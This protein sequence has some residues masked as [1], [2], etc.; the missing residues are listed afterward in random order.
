VKQAR[1]AEPW[2]SLLTGPDRDFIAAVRGELIPDPGLLTMRSLHAL[3]D[4]DRERYAM[5]RTKWHRHLPIIRL[6]SRDQ[7]YEQFE[8]D[9][10]EDEWS[11]GDYAEGHP[12][13]VLDGPPGVGKSTLL[14][15]EMASSLALAARSRWLDE[16]DEVAPPSTSYR[17]LPTYQPVIR[18]RHTSASTVPTIVA[19]LLGKLGR[20]VG[21]RPHESLA[22]ALKECRTSLI[23]FDEVQRVNFDRK[24]GQHV[25][26]LLRELSE[27]HSRLILAGNDARWMLERP[28]MFGATFGTDASADRWIVL[29]VNPLGYDDEVQQ[30]EWRQF[31]AAIEQRVR[32]CALP[33]RGWLSDGL[34]DYLYALSEGRFN[35]L[36]GVLKRSFVRAIAN[37]S[38]RVDRA[39]LERARVEWTREQNRLSRTAELD[40][41]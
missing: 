12:V 6:S 28:K 30:V 3:P 33:E 18:F 4:L 35:T 39:L 2:L 37:G 11:R 21:P 22:L 27:G 17:H 5:R 1:P 23:V 24:T 41:D 15:A 7:I 19:G 38:E 29:R 10:R 36:L 8:V 34:S 31:L 25:H 40:D 20:P 13:S 16:D 32:L 9:R 14:R 26:G